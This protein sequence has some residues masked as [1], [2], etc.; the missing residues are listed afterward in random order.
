MRRVPAGL[1]LAL[2][3]ILGARVG[4]AQDGPP[5]TP[6][7][8][9][10][11]VALRRDLQA[12]GLIAALGS[13]SRLAARAG[14]RSAGWVT[15]R[16]DLLE[17][18]GQPIYRLRDRL[19]FDLEGLGRASLR[20]EADVRPDLGALRVMLESEEPRG[21][22]SVSRVRVELRREPQG[23]VRYE[24]RAQ[25]APKATPVPDLGEAPLV[26][27]PPLG[28]GERLARLAPARL[29]ESLAL[30]A[31]D[32]ET[33]LT[34]R[35]RL[36]V[37]EAWSA[38][39]AGAVASPGFLV[40][41]R[42]GGALLSAWRLATPGAAPL[43]LRLRRLELRDDALA[44]ERAPGAGTPAEAV[45]ALLRAL[46]AGDAEATARHL[47]LGAL[48]RAAGGALDRAREQRFGQVAL[49]R[50]CAPAWLERHGLALL[51]A[52][53]AGDLEVSVEGQR[54]RVW[55]RGQTGL[56]FIVERRD[57]AWRVVALP[58]R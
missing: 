19:A 17:H 25:G 24:V 10:R 28:A 11:G 57:A 16:T 48:Y 43:R 34:T 38:Q 5:S 42:E 58:A 54:A 46:A 9:E 27:T 3:A 37:D 14:G 1:A 26:L 31:Y 20:V 8:A 36:S 45:C 49:A 2:C 4:R 35:W 12:G 40:R 53:V 47:D 7:P 32:L 13:E 15:L 21:E 6:T 33:G 56:V 52:A 50:L 41:R 23:W 29:G 22:G 44:A 51:G 30:P 18:D 39:V 55:P